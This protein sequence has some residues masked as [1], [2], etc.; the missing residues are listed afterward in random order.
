MCVC[1]CVQNWWDLFGNG[2]VH[3]NNTG[4]ILQVT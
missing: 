3:T 1:V 2:P 4:I